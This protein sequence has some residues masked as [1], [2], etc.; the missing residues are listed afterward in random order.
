MTLAGEIEETATIQKY[1]IEAQHWNV[2]Y[3]FSA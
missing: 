2:Y 3:S 1:I